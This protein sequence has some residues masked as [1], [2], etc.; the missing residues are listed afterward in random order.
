MYIRGLIPRNFAELAKAVP[1]A[2]QVGAF[3][4]DPFIFHVKPGFFKGL[5]N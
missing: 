2:F 1:I 4:V 3:S 5:N